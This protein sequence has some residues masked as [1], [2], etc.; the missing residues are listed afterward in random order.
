MKYVT[1]AHATLGIC[2][3]LAFSLAEFTKLLPENTKVHPLVVGLG[4]AA[5]AVATFVARADRI[6]LFLQKRGV[7]PGGPKLGTEEKT[8]VEKRP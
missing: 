5:L 6:L 1:I 7:V 2:G 8:P 3:A 4:A